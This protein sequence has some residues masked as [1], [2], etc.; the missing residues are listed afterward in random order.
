MKEVSY[1][2]QL[3]IFG[4]D[5]RHLIKVKCAHIIL[6]KLLILFNMSVN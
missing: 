4:T 2:W 1:T 6:A 5:P 3:I